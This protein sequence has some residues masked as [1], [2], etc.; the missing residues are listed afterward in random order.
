MISHGHCGAQTSGP[1][2]NM[3]M[4]SYHYRKSYCGDKTILRPL[5]LHN[6]IAFTGKTVSL[7]WVG[8]QVLPPYRH[9]LSKHSCRVLSMWISMVP[10]VIL[11]ILPQKYTM[12]SQFL[13]DPLGPMQNF[14]RAWLDFQGPGGCFTNISQALP[15]H[16]FKICIL[17]KLYFL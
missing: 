14:T 2:F 11:M 5:Y 10:K 8:A 12:N 17:Q 3:K 9:I 13:D 16:S 1:W 6:G 15:R 7:Y 4:S